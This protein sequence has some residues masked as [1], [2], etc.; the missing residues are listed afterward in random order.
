MKIYF[1]RHGQS[2]LNIDNKEQGAEGALSE[3]GRRQAEFV[4]KRFSDIPI[5]L[6]V[7]SPYERAKETAE[8]INS[9][10][11]KELVFSDLLV[12]RR[13]ASQFIG[14]KGD[15]PEL[16]KATALMAEQRMTDP[17]WRYADE[18]NFTELKARAIQALAYL[19]GLEKEA[20][21]AV[22]HGG[23]LRVIIAAMVMGDDLT[24]GE[25]VKFLSAFR[26]QNTGITLVERGTDP[27]GVERWLLMAWNDH[28][29]L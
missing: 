7:A 11:N 24:Y 10:L 14:M 15:D 22:T 1:V 26:T 13:P 17:S 8:I 6:I 28:A 16:R 27:K 25:Y 19:G 3:L 21:L 9:H 5:D 4:A 29:H 20:V 12:E 23:I 2:E 18:E